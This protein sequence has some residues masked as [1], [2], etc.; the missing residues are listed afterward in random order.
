MMRH[1]RPGTGLAGR[2]FTEMA[3]TARE[4]FM[5]GAGDESEVEGSS[6]DWSGQRHRLAGPESAD[7][8]RV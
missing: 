8:C 6:E 5:R 4:V 7:W 2:E 1:N 3:K